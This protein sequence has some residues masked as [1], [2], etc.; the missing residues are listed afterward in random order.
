MF[1]G[2]LSLYVAAGIVVLHVLRADLDP[3]VLCPV[4]IGIFVFVGVFIAD[5]V[6]LGLV[7]AGFLIADVIA[8]GFVAVR[9][10]IAGVIALGFVA[11]RFFIAGVVTLGAVATGFF[12]AGV[13]VL[14]AVATGFFIAG[15]VTL[16]TVTA[17]IVPIGLIIARGIPA[18]G[19]VIR[20]VFILA[21]LALCPWFRR[22]V[23]IRA[24]LI[25]Y[26]G[27]RLRFGRIT[28]IG[29]LPESGKEDAQAQGQCKGPLP[30]TITSQNTHSPYYVL[31]IE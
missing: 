12:I 21:P 23:W 1:A 11:V 10:F 2:V 13:A 6:T 17:G 30:K 15:V 9:F 26:L 29:N 7:A 28:R 20:D 18:G 22:T 19:T 14:G 16:G 5:V 3:L 4:A 25:Y 24:C 31:Y 8:L 27:Y